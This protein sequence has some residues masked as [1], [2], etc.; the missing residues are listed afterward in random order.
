MTYLFAELVLDPAWPRP[1]AWLGVPGVLAAALVLAALTVWTYA[2]QRGT[3]VGR[4]LAV[5]AP[6]LGAL[7]VACL[8]LLRPAFAD[9]EQAVLPSKLLFVLDSSSSMNITD[10][11][12]GQSRWDAA[13]RLLQ[14]PRI[15]ALLRRLQN[16]QKVEILYYQGA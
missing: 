4:V 9:R 15:A 12:N 2:G 13:R 1:L 5:L 11:Y 7:L 8:V 16:E 6:P 14:A 3:T 10:E